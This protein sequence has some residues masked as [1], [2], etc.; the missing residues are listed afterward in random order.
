MS[1]TLIELAFTEIREIVPNIVT[2]FSPDDTASKVLGVLKEAG[3]YE[4]AVAME[5]SFGIITVRDMLDVDQPSQTRIEG[6]WR[7]TSSVS[8]GSTVLDAVEVLVR[9]N[10]RAVP[11]VE[12]GRVIGM[13]SQVDVVRA[14]C[15]VPELSGY[16]AKELIR[17]PV[18][19]LDI[20]ERLS[21]ACRLMLERRISHIP[22]VE[23]GKLVGEVTAE[24]IVH[25]F[26]TPASKTTTGER[27]GRRT[28]R[29]P[30]LVTGIMDTQPLSIQQ[31]ASMLDV[32][33]GLRDK[34]KGACYMVGAR[35]EIMGVL[36][37][38]ELMAPL[39]RLRAVKELPVYI[40]GLEDEGFF[41]REVAEE[42][43]RRMVRRSMRFR[44]DITEVSVMIKSSQTRGNRT[45]YELT[46]RALTQEGQI[47]AKAGG[48]DLLRVFDELC[49]TLDKAIRRTKPET[50]GRLRRRRS[51]R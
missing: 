22:V 41:E 21:Y 46:G 48:W 27:V 29:F 47:N 37:P 23:Y 25:T 4:A 26:I 1:A 44:P 30:G 9:N 18:W 12:K 40:R 16:A 45:R 34:G 39:L 31:D 14:M 5:D 2:V 51:R 42:K 50:P 24:D 19:S 35:R 11:L 20:D 7:G 43:V 38:R 33:R 8:P 17:S 49:D 6:I 36:T 3:L 15:G 28:S 32:V 10:I 13:A